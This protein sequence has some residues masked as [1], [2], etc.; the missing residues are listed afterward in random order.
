MTVQNIIDGIIDKTGMCPLPM[1]RTCDRLMTGE[2]DMEVKKIVTTFMATVDVIREAIRLGANFIITH[3]PTWFTGMDQTDWLEGDPVYQEKRKLLEEN[4]IAVWRFHDHMHMGAEDGIY[5]G[6][7][8][9]FGWAAYRMPDVEGSTMNR[10]G[11]CYEIPE[12]TLKG[13]GMFFRSRLGMETV[14]IVGDPEMPVKRVSVLVGGG[15]LG[16]GLEQR[17]MIQMRERDIDVVI[18]GDITEWTL[19]AYVRDASALGLQKGM[20]V[21]GHERSEEWG[22]KYLG[23]WMESITGELEVVFVDAGEPF[24]YI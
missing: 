11:A 13:M 17:P 16:L 15:S 21:L 9:E 18:C 4:R 10:F 20:L 24:N 8:K 2:A 1:E 12:T 19:S 23:E 14:Q 3:E 6:L 7:E 22:M 5:R